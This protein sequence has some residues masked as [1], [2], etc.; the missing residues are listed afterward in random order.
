MELANSLNDSA[1]NSFLKDVIYTAYG[2][3]YPVLN[4]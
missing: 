3:S 4:I 1:A 2:G